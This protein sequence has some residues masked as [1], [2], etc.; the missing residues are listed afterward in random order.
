MLSNMN[1]VVIGYGSMGQNHVRT[2]RSLGHNVAHVV[3]PNPSSTPP[4]DINL[5][6][7][8]DH[9]QFDSIDGVII[10][11][12]TDA[13]EKIFEEIVNAGVKNILCEKPALIPL[14]NIPRT[15]NYWVGFVETYNPAFKACKDLV[16]SGKIGNIKKVTCTRVGSMPRNISQSKNVIVDLASHDIA[17]V[18]DLLGRAINLKVANKKCNTA[19]VTTSALLTD[20]NDQIM[21]SCDSSWDVANKR[22]RIEI[23]GSEGAIFADLANQEVAWKP[24]EFIGQSAFSFL[25]NLAWSSKTD[26]LQLGITKEEPLMKELK[27]FCESIELKKVCREH[28][29]VS[30]SLEYFKDV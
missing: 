24:N 22:R 21:V 14:Q 12:P 3:D 7:A 4:A 13:H 26:S 25:D 23:Y 8:I 30:Q 5:T 10:S 2:L 9:V 6:A 19:G 1:F 17:L 27:S 15:V 28:V 11:A 16:K 20:D 29:N 18:F